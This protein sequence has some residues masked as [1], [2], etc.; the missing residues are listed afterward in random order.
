M[1]KKLEFSTVNKRNWLISQFAEIHELNQIQKSDRPKLLHI[2]KVCNQSNSYIF[3]IRVDMNNRSD[4][5]PLV[6]YFSLLFAFDGINCWRCYIQNENRCADNTR[7]S[8][9]CAY[10]K[11]HKSKCQFLTRSNALGMRSVVLWFRFYFNSC[12]VFLFNEIIVL[13]GQS[14]FEVWTCHTSF[15]IYVL[16]D[17]NSM[18]SLRFSNHI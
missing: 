3:V 12:A 13:V 11:I 2:A 10:F 8:I 18:G 15:F 16:Y 6:L 1:K 9:L 4:R 5:Q 17:E 7:S 14:L